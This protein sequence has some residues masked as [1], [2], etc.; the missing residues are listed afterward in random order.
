MPR[1][2]AVT[3]LTGKKSGGEF[4]RVMRDNAETICNMFPGGVRAL[5]RP[6]S[7][8]TQLKNTMP[9]IEICVGELSDEDYL[10]NA[11]KDVDTVINIAGIDFSKKIADAAVANKVKRIILVHTTGVYSK[12]K[13][14]GEGYRKT[15]EYV[16]D[17]CKKN[18]IK[19]TILRPT[20][21][22]GNKH[23]SN[24]I[25]FIKMVDKFP[26]MPVVSGAKYF[27]QPVHYKDL[28]KAYYGVLV[29]EATTA[30]KDFILSGKTPI[31]LRNMFKIIG[32][33]LGKNVVFLSC[34]FFVAYAGACIIYFLT[35]KRKDYREKV[36]RLCESRT[37]SHADAV[38]AFGYS[39]VDFEKGIID[40]VKEYLAEKCGN[41]P[42]LKS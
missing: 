1:L 36:Q 11:L 26:I 20:M 5:V 42:R 41:Q 31:M 38:E 7:D 19:L 25:I 32:D 17:I 37:F 13:A 23:D 34:P 18:N 14:A 27:L 10:Q 9:D 15:D 22:Y 40:E 12:Y 8:T 33:N 28:A 6:G 35:S 21:I 16:Y 2:L 4:A 30:G 24:L 3:G 39:P 29:N